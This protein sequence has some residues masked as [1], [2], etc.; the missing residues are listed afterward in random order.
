MTL[1][2]VIDGV[3]IAMLESKCH[4]R[5]QIVTLLV[6]I[7][8]IQ[9]QLCA[10]VNEPAQFSVSEY[11]EVNHFERDNLFVIL[12]THA[13]FARLCRE[14]KIDQPSV[15]PGLKS[16]L[17]LRE[18]TLS[19]K[20]NE[21]TAMMQTRD[22]R[23]HIDGRRISK[24]DVRQTGTRRLAQYVSELK[25][26]EATA[27]TIEALNDILDE[28][29][30]QDA[31]TDYIEIKNTEGN[32]LVGAVV[33]MDALDVIIHKKDT[34]YFRIPLT[35]LSGETQATITGE[36]IANWSRLTGWGNPYMSDK[37]GQLNVIAYDDEYLF[38][39]EYRGV[40]KHP[41]GSTGYT[42]EMT[43]DT[44][45]R[46]IDSEFINIGDPVRIFVSQ[47]SLLFAEEA[48]GY[49]LY[50]VES[51]GVPVFLKSYETVF[52]SPGWADVHIY[53]V[54]MSKAITWPNGSSSKLKIYSQV[55]SATLKKHNEVVQQ[56]K[57]CEYGI[58][59]NRRR[60]R[61]IEKHASNGNIHVEGPSIDGLIS[62]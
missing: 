14:H 56:L 5:Q 9:V 25:D 48:D 31:I 54:G 17:E 53:Y 35:T 28:V 55:P 58:A 18:D 13:S 42:L 29:R 33:M 36:L 15:W 44:L 27:N 19:K 43:A 45:E 4:F 23:S 49:I 47:E 40:V 10:S 37:L 34:G 57:A 20:I 22:M 60:I 16:K 39:N 7:V 59:E 46:I 21:A 3:N 32:R 51:G 11:L 6:F 41:R 30:R 38:I 52:T 50:V 12:K 62:K 2:P 8:L 1:L 61:L 24:A 26:I